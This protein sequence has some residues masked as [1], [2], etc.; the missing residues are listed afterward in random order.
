MLVFVNIVFVITSILLMNANLYTGHNLVNMGSNIFWFFVYLVIKHIPL[1]IEIPLYISF[2]S[3]TH[4]F[5]SLTSIHLMLIT[6][7][8][9]KSKT[10]IKICKIII[11]ISF[12]LM[13]ACY[14]IAILYSLEVKQNMEIELFIETYR[15]YGPL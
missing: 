5:L 11:F 13:L 7:L 6:W 2:I 14:L 3:F 12:F 1:S 9:G 15:Y 8:L 4:L 10:L